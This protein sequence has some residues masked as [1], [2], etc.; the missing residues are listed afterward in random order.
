MKKLLAIGFA[1]ALGACAAQQTA[2][3]SAATPAAEQEAAVQEKAADNGDK[4]SKRDEDYVSSLER[5]DVTGSRINRVRRRG[6][7]EEDT[8]AGKR[9]ETISREE[10]EM[11][12]QRTRGPIISGE[13]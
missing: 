8:T 1:L 4:R 10:I 2:L 6:E 3:Q 9:V 11:M 13:E 5:R 12:E 7:A